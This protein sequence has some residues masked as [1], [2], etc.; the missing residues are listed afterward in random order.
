MPPIRQKPGHPPERFGQG[1][2]FSAAGGMR[3]MG[4]AVS[5][6]SGAKTMVPSGLQVPPPTVPGASA[7]EIAAP[8]EAF[9]LYSMP[10]YPGARKEGPCFVHSAVCWELRCAGQYLKVCMQA[11]VAALVLVGVAGCGQ[12][13]N[14]HHGDDGVRSVQRLHGVPGSARRRQGHLLARTSATGPADLCDRP[15]AV[16]RE[17]YREQYCR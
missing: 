13:P 17:C 2:G 1:G 4:F 16:V 8:P 15:V 7:R 10:V 5:F 11:G 6:P 3:A 9:I 12:P 14:A